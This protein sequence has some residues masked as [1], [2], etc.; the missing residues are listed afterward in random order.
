MLDNPQS[1]LNQQVQQTAQQTNKQTSQLASQQTTPDGTL[2]TPDTQPSLSTPKPVE[3]KSNTD[4]VK[5]PEEGKGFWAKLKGKATD[6]GGKLLKDK[7]ASPTPEHKTAPQST[8]SPQSSPASPSPQT[9][10]VN[11]PT[12]NPPAPSLKTP[13]L[14]RAPIPKIPKLR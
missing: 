8:I 10:K 7:L 14:A 11:S 9:P 4:S 6:Q 5:S 12:A 1:K 2:M 3:L 13:K